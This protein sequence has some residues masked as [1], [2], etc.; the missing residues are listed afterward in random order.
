MVVLSVCCILLTRHTFLG[1]KQYPRSVGTTAKVKNIV[2]APT[3]HHSLRCEGVVVHIT[4]KFL[5]VH[6]KHSLSSQER[7]VVSCKTL[8]NQKKL[9]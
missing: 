8:Q 4:T 9:C 3:D 2:L 6:P 7:R 5:G 1:H